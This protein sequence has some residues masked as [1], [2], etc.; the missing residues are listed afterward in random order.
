[1]NESTVTKPSFL[2]EPLEFHI[3]HPD[4]ETRVARITGSASL[5]AY[6]S[7]HSLLGRRLVASFNACREVE[8]PE[9][10]P[11]LFDALT[12]FFEAKPADRAKAIDN[13]WNAAVAAGVL[14][15]ED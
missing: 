2:N 7:V 4:D 15:D 6:G 11:K 1:M 5:R 12:K 3:E 13:L 8:R 10:L 9:E 14:T